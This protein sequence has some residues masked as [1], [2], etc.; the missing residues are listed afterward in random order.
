MQDPSEMQR[1]QSKK[2]ADHAR[3]IGNAK[4]AKQKASRSYKTN[5]KCKESKAKRKQIEQDS[6]E[7]QRKQSKKQADRARPI[8]NAKKAKQKPM[9]LCKTHRKYSDLTF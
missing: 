5:R 1:K 8:G 7:M 6:L 2:Q 3:P 9:R 4:K